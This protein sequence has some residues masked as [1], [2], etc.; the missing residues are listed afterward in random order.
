MSSIPPGLWSFEPLAHR[1]G[2]GHFGGVGGEDVAV[3]VQS[4]WRF[5]IPRLTGVL[6]LQSL[7]KLCDV[8]I[9]LE[10]LNIIPQKTNLTLENKLNQPDS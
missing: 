4:R 3:A 2:H 5:R 6:F 7:Q 8:F 10:F 1:L 9:D